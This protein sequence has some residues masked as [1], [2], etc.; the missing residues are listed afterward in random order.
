MRLAA[1]AL[2]WGSLLFTPAY[3]EPDT[4]AKPSSAQAADQKKPEGDTVEASAVE[5]AHSVARSI[6]FHGATLNYTVTPG[7]L[8]I[9]NDD[10]L[11]TAS[12]FYVAY[13]VKP[14][15][16]APPRPIAFLYNGGPGSSS[17]WLHLGSFGPLKIAVPTPDMLPAP[18]VH[19]APNPD[20]LLD[21]TDLVFIDA[22]TTGLSR[23]LGKTEAKTVFGVDGDLDAFSRAIQ[24]YLKI[25]GRWDSPKFLIGE[26]YG[27]LR[28]A[29]LAL[30]LADKGVQLNGVTLLS[31]TLNIGLLFQANDQGYV[32]MVPTLAATAWYHNR[33]ANKPADLAA[34]MAQVRAFASG[35]YAAALAK[36]YTLPVAE[37]DAVAAQ[38]GAY[39]GVSPQVILNNNL[40]L[41]ADRFRKELMRSDRKTV[42]RLDS[43]F[44]G[45]DA[46][47]GG[48]GTEYDPSDTA[49]TGAWVSAINDYLFHD[50]GYETNLTYR[51]DNYAAQGGE[52]WN[53]RH[54]IPGLGGQLSADTSVDLAAAL[55]QNPRLK[56]LDIAGYY[57]MAT[58]FFGA[59]Y[60]LTHMPIDA[61]R[62]ANVTFK[63]Y[64]SGHMV[65]IEPASAKQ[66]R[67]DIESW[68]DSAK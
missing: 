67:L 7:T 2:V 9:R 39:I 23:M 19:L 35:A 33:L 50:L 22:P 6:P 26:S 64:P 53:W 16:G 59:E 55:R 20:T 48:E 30:L 49:M 18:P 8:T 57:D 3:A 46:D 45:E 62:Q 21:K 36:G 61:D 1:L 66:L 10:G 65:Y 32:N 63:Y 56:L 68:M 43:R 37:R 60:D 17:M 4:T 29:G 15:P 41:D 54:K 12:L 40:R 38:L 13:T 11:A 28:S 52:G 58:P 24:R 5:T 47:A 31:T 42:G 25:Y 34:Y 14:A 27:T 51:P 44:L